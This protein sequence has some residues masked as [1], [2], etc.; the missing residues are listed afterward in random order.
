[1]LFAGSE[2]G[3]MRKQPHPFY[4]KQWRQ[5]R[6]LTQQ[7]LADRVNLS[8]P[9]IS[10]MERGKKGYSQETLEALAEALM[11]EPADLIMRDPTSPDP[12]WSVW[13]KVPATKRNDALRVLAAFAED[14][15]KTGT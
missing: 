5:H 10:E 13:D 2:N 8:K 1:M 4:L 15:A 12:I 9:F 11:C 6:G 3:A 7:R 14:S